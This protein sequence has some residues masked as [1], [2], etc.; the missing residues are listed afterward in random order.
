MQQ[1]H[2]LKI[3]RQNVFNAG[4]IHFL[5]VFD[6]LGHILQSIVVYFER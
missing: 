1:M 6:P 5:H 2:H 4:H 3:I